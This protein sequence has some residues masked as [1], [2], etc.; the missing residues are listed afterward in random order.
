MKKN[1]PPSVSHSHPPS[2][3][4]T[5]LE[6][7]SLTVLRG[8]I[9]STQT[10][11]PRRFLLAKRA[12]TQAAQTP[13]PHPQFQSTPRFGSSSVPRPTQRRDVGVEDVDDEDDDED[14][15]DESDAAGHNTGPHWEGRHLRTQDSIE[16]ESDG[17]SASQSEEG[18]TDGHDAAPREADALDEEQHMM[19]NAHQPPSPEVRQ[20]KRRRVSISPDPESPIQRS[21][22]PLARHHADDASASTDSLDSSQQTHDAPE[23][24][25]SADTERAAAEDAGPPPFRR[26]AGARDTSRA[27]WRPSC[28]GGCPRSRAGKARTR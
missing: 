21:T 15:E 28:K 8:G 6:F 4:S 9:W 23:G 1:P 10:P 25:D 22:S 13:A 12:A 14:D 19:L 26:S 18:P 27:D 7:S 17:A 20:V 5:F 3:T 11:T 2:S 24:L 16:V